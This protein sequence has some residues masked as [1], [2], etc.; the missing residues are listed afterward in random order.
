MS[1]VLPVWM[2]WDRSPNIKPD[3][4]FYFDEM[5]AEGAFN[6]FDTAAAAAPAVTAAPAIDKKQRG[7][8]LKSKQFKS[9][10]I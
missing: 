2:C 10:L 1:T 4:A 7:R 6:R 8:K 5:E 9:L 3:S